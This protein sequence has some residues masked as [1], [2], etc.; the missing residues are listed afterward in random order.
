MNT[1]ADF[2][3]IA[4]TWLQ[5]GPTELPD[6]SLEAA[7]AEVH[8][9]SQRRFG[10]VRR[11]FPEM[12]IS[13]QLAAA[14]VVGILL[15]ALGAA[16]FGRNASGGVGGGPTATPT[17]G[18]S[19]APTPWP[20][21]PPLTQTFTSSLHGYSI[22]YPAGWTVFPATAAWPSGPVLNWGSAGLD[23][24]R[25]A[26]QLQNATTRLVGT[27]QPLA[28][29]QSAEAWMRANT[30]RGADPSAWRKVAIGD[31]TGFIDIEGPSP[32]GGSIAPGGY[33]FD[34]LVVVDGRGYNFTL[35]G[36]VNYDYFVA[37][38]ATVVF[39]AASAV[40]P[41]AAP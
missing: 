6:R 36:Y 13:W 34:A 40:D 21:V 8:V 3:R 2:D 19:A 12:K 24:L 26:P 39:D 18:P 7:L 30:P 37:I 33:G 16:Y 9:T 32:A 5:D 10:A 28:A 1:N 17:P 4:Q 20:T 15:I 14:A 23:Q 27:S 41:T 31:Q 38:M 35:D 25:N 22:K 11:T 29:G